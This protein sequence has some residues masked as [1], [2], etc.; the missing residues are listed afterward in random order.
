MLDFLNNADTI[1]EAFA[2]YYRTTI[3]ADETDP[4][5]LHDLQA[6]L[7]AAQVY[8]SEQVDDLVK[9]YLGGANRDQLDPVLDACAEI[10]IHKPEKDAQIDFKSKAKAFVRT[11][12]FLSCVCPT[13]TPSGRNARS[14]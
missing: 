10:Y 8:S 14:S 2:D 9:R 4:D 7:D 1:R 12:N 3:L 6:D 5:K 13:R 11:Y